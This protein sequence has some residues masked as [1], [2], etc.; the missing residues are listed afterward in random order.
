MA[1]ARLLQRTRCDK[2]AARGE[3]RTLQ[4]SGNHGDTLLESAIGVPQTLLIG[5]V[6]STSKDGTRLSADGRH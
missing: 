2:P 1:V 5:A 4:P 6:P 3:T